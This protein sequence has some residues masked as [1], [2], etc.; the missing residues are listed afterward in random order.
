METDH[1]T[2]AIPERMDP[3]QP[4]MRRRNRGEAIRLDDFPGTVELTE[5][6]K[7]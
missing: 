4:V 2:V 1:P 6:A 7:P 5:P 3:G